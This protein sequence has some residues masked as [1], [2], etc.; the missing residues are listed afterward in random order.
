MIGPEFWR[1]YLKVYD[2][3]NSLPT[4]RQL[5]ADVCEELGV[6]ENEL[7]MDAGSGTG[8]LALR[9]RGSG[10]KVVAIDYCREALESH[11]S[12][13]I[14][15]S[16]VL[17]D[18]ERGLPFKDNCFDKIASNNTLYAMS[19]VHQKSALMELRRVL[20]TG[21]KIVLANPRRRLNFLR[22]SMNV[23]SDSIRAEGFGTTARKMVASMPVMIMM[24][25]Y[26][27]KL[28]TDNQHCFYDYEEQRDLLEDMGFRQVSQTKLIYSGQAVLNSAIK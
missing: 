25:Y 3:L 15:C 5:L 8:N 13:D 18:L 23:I 20:K 2:V 9:I 26:N 7:I 27:R 14:H 28:R 6:R 21:G 4:Y 1:R 19:A 16:P 10:G 17:A 24:A 12:K 22:V 11:R